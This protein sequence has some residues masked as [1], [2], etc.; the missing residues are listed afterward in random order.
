[1]DQTRMPG[2]RATPWW[3]AAL[4]VLGLTLVP[5]LA[6]LLGTL[7]EHDLAELGVALF[8]ERTPTTQAS[9]ATP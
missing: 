1:M 6:P 8:G 3:P 4:L 2:E 5:L 7:D 9:L